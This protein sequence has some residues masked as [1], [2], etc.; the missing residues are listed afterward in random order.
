MP[1]DESDGT[2]V[3]LWHQ[4]AGALAP[5]VP[6]TTK[7]STPP[8]CSCRRPK[9]SDPRGVQCSFQRSQDVLP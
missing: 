4:H 7:T 5:T 3:A 9:V 8:T 1:N 6:P 2:A